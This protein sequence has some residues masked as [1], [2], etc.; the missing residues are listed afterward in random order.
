M[1]LYLVGGAV[2]DKILGRESADQDFVLIRGTE[3]DLLDLVPGAVRVGKGIPVFVRGQAQYTC[4][5]FS[6]IEADLASRDLTINAL[7]Q[8]EHGQV[9][10]H[11]AALDD[12][13]A[14]VLRPVAVEN[15][16]ADPLRAVRA[17]RF[18]AQFPDFTVSPELLAAMHCVDADVLAQV[19]AERVGHEVLKAC[20]APGPGHFLRTLSQGKC[21][22]PWFAEW[23]EAAHIPAGPPAFHTESVL[24]HTATVMD[25][26]AGS[27][28]RVWMAW[29][30][31][32]GKTAT[33]A[34]L[35]PRHLGHEGRGLDLARA[36]ASRLRLP[37][38]YIRTGSL[39]AAWHM[40]GAMYPQLRASTRVRLLLEAD[41]AGVM[42]EL[43]TLIHAD[44]GVDHVDLARE[45]LRLIKAVRLP[46][47][48][49][50]LGPKSAAIL[51]TMRCEALSR[52]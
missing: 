8:D 16:L 9:V 32:I 41:K 48:H 6:D 21:L 23:A 7:A 40:A 51:L 47:K 37:N 1:K 35:L 44:G 26:C 17:A 13:R 19:A 28:L 50:N 2:R 38:A 36:F 42:D 46:E 11:P 24:E 31:D 34:E 29:C 43:F 12:L 52:P 39:A 14:K 30:H 10:A 18:S 27:A 15:F 20:A 49:R 4:S 33:P 45:E 22:A 5:A 3:N 25:R